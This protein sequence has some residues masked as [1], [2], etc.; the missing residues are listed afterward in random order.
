MFSFEL[1]AYSRAPLEPE[2]EN[3]IVPSTLDHFVASVVTNIV[4]L[5]SLEQIVGGHLVAT[6]QQS[7]WKEQQTVVIKVHCSMLFKGFCLLLT[8]SLTWR[9]EHWRSVPMSL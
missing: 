1:L 2:L 5:I 8:L 6:D 4:H 3:I 7:L 9:V